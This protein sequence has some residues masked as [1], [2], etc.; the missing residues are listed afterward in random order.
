MNAAMSRMTTMMLCTGGVT[1]VPSGEF[2]SSWLTMSS[3]ESHPEVTT[4]LTMPAT[5]QMPTTTTK[6][7]LPMALAVNIMMKEH[8]TMTTQGTTKMASENVLASIDPA[9]S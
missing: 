4:M 5:K 2:A 1:V 6:S 8:T 7:C 9:A 3:L